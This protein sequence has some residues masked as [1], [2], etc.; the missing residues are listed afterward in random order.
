MSACNGAAESAASGWLVVAG[1]GPG[2]ANLLTPEVS[3]ALAEATDVVGYFPYVARVG[4][5]GLELPADLLI[6]GYELR[7]AV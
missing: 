1:L 2:D 3:A 4:S 5:A 6:A 7:Q